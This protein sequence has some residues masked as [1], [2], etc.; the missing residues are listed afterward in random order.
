M[1]S[2]TLYLDGGVASY[3]DEWIKAENYISTIL[4]QG[5]KLESIPTVTKIGHTFLGWYDDND[6]KVDLTKEIVENIKLTAKWEANEYIVTLNLAG[7]TTTDSYSTTKKIKY[8]DVYGSLP[9]VKKEGYTF[10]GWTTTGGTIIKENTVLTLASDHTIYAGWIANTYK[11][12]FVYGDDRP[13]T[14]KEVTYGSTYGELPTPTMMGYQFKGWYYN[15]TKIDSTTKVTKASDQVLIALWEANKYTITFVYNNGSANTTKEVTYGST[16]GELPTPTKEGYTFN[17]WSTSGGSV[18]TSSSV[19]KITS[20]TTLYAQWGINSYLITFNPTGGVTSVPNKQIKY[21]DTYGELP[22]PTR[23][24][25][26]FVAWYMETSLTNKVTSS[27]VMNTASNHT[28]YAGW[29]ANKYTLTLSGMEYKN[30][31]VVYYNPVTNTKCNSSEAV[32]TTG[33][34]TGCMKWY[35][36]ND[37]GGTKVKLLLDHNT[38]AK[39]AWR[40]SGNNT[41]GILEANTALNNDISSWNSDVKASARLLTAYDIATI[42]GYNN[43]NNISYYVHSNTTTEYRGAAGTNKYA[44]LFDNTIN[45]TIFGCNTNDSS[46]YGYWTTT[47]YSKDSYYAWYMSYF[48]QLS[49]AYITTSGYYGVRPVIEIDRSVIGTTSVTK[50]VTYDSAYGQLATPKKAGYEFIGWYTTGGVK[51]NTTDLYKVAGNQTLYAQWKFATYVISFDSTGGSEISTTKNVTYNGTYGELPT[52]TRFAYEFAGWYTTSGVKITSTSKVEITSNTTLYAQWNLLFAYYVYDTSNSKIAQTKTLSE[53]LDKS[54]NN[55][56]I[57]IVTSTKEKDNITLNKNVK[58]DTN[59]YILDLDKYTIKVPSTYT[60]NITGTGII[61]GSS[62]TILVEGGTLNTELATI[63]STEGTTISNSSGTTTINSGTIYSMVGYAIYTNGGTLIINNGTIYSK[64][65]Y[66]TIGDWYSNITINSGLIYS[67]ARTAINLHGKLNI[68]TNDSNMSTTSP[69][70]R[71][72]TNGIEAYTRDARI[73]FYGGRIYYDL[74]RTGDYS[75]ISGG[76]TTFIADTMWKKN[77]EVVNEEKYYSVYRVE[78]TEQNYQ[79]LNSSGSHVAYTST[80]Q[81][82]YDKSQ[83]GYKIKLLKDVKDNA[84]DIK[85]ET[86]IDTNGYTLDL[87]GTTFNISHKMILNITGNGVV[88]STSYVAY[89]TYGTINIDSATIYSSGSSAIYV[90]GSTTPGYINIK[91]GTIR[92][93]ASSAI[94]SDSGTI[95][96]GTNDSNISTTSPIIIGKTHGIYEYFGSGNG[97]TYFY[98]GVIYYGISKYS[99]Y[100]PYF[101]ET[102]TYPLNTKWTITT[103]TLDGVEYNKAYRTSVTGNNYQIL[104][105]SGNHIAYAPTLAGAHDKA[106]DGYTIKLL[107]DMDD[108]GIEISKNI[109]L[110]TNGFTLNI[111]ANAIGIEKNCTVNIIGKGVIDS[112]TLGIRNYYGVLNINDV[113]V[114]GTSYGIENYGDAITNINSGTIYASN[115][116]IYNLWGIVNINGGTIYASGYAVYEWGEKGQTNIYGGLIYS[117]NS[118]AI[119]NGGNVIIGKDDS[120]IS[121]TSPIIRGRTYAIEVDSVNA[122]TLSIYDGKLYYDGG[123]TGNYTVINN[124]GNITI[125]YAGTSDVTG[126]EDVDGKTYK[127]TYR[128]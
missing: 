112:K 42:T 64:K 41:N 4:E 55:Y 8:G 47:P 62:T 87:I 78:Y 25:Y 67:E 37:D 63:Y 19:V 17:A 119:R 70:I 106:A 18:I 54:S 59:G 9:T 1:V 2:V 83:A 120:T 66:S 94:Y 50:E 15:S 126:T 122:K 76:I 36:F 56:T 24:G 79:I 71:G 95:T 121:N 75:P 72:K 96:V 39:V 65:G 110:D 107:K 102:A 13:N 69:I 11:V 77:E 12:T 128:K 100:Y 81:G 108:E 115:N 127:Y 58:F 22:T 53:A 34:K 116:G 117:V 104:N 48:G 61:K 14:T 3:N 86:T 26:T 32:S 6:E 91:S 21:K 118:S 27:T 40:S 111:G 113:T 101:N 16:Y 124:P 85:K 23:D 49:T 31:E 93:D 30:G 7:G 105:A 46:T 88:K 5:S 57:K 73:T 51:I 109:T 114:K 38:T 43:W 44:W 10:A 29:K 28:L 60:L 90:Y 74:N 89:N 125:N 52:P 97:H 103:E 82:A 68:G 20:N 80:L 99:T 84:L 123:N 45:C 35:A 98:D 92:S 33:T